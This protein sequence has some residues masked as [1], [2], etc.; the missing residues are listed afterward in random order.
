[1]TTELLCEMNNA[2]KNSGT[3]FIL[4]SLTH[5]I[6]VDEE[7]FKE[8]EERHPDMALGTDVLDKRLAAFSRHEGIAY[9]SSLSAMRELR[10]SGKFAHL[11]C[12]GHWSRD[13]HRRVAELLVDY[14][15]SGK[16]ICTPR[17]SQ[18]L[19]VP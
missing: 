6:Q 7:M 1:M 18:H 13:A 15:I 10:A 5:A 12:D 19:A 2:S 16:H 14:L 9:V 3:E 11:S 17:C 8:L 4:F